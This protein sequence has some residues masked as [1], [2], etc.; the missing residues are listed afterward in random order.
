MYAAFA[1]TSKTCG[2]GLAREDGGT[3]SIFMAGTPLSRASPL[4][5]R[6]EGV[7]SLCMHQ[8]DLWERACPRRR[9]HIQHLHDRHS[10]FAG[11]PAPTQDWGCTQPLHT[12]ARPVGAG[13]PA[14]M[15]AHSASSWQTL[16]FRGQARS[17]PGLRVY[18]AF[19]CTSKTCGSGLAREGGGTVNGPPENTPM[20]QPLPVP[21][22]RLF[23]LLPPDKYPATHR[24][25][26]IT[27]PDQKSTLV[28]FRCV[29]LTSKKRS[30][31]L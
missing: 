10:A 7:R 21:A 16:R 24:K 3:F 23:L 1:C 28:A 31:T 12:P 5:P 27:Q 25:L 11:K 9:R 19:A 6:I 14:K 4:P 18:A 29:S 30:L 20:R 22:V 13:L 15:V 26:P 2:S 8:Q 17:H